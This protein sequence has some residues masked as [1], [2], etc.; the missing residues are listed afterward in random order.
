MWQWQTAYDELATYVWNPEPTT[1]TYYFGIPLDY[2]D[3]FSKTTSMF[4]FEVY[5]SRE[6]LYG[7]HLS[8]PAMARFLAAIPA[9]STTGLDLSHCRCVSGYV[10]PTGD[11][12]E[13]GIMQ[14]T[15][16]VCISPSAR[17]KTLA[18]LQK[19]AERVERT[20]RA[21]I[22]K[23]V[24]TYQVFESLDDEISARIFARFSDRE[25]MERFLRREEVVGFWMGVK[26]EVKSME[27]RGYLP[28]GKGWLHC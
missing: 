18:S 2:A 11:K 14:D 23:S 13:C 3:D 28:N 8:S 26:E 4:A 7:T 25:A 22:R 21:A 15:R 17:G 1:L 5:G 9:F 24:Y 19:L 6:D 10:D 16:I 20:E 27:C 12:P